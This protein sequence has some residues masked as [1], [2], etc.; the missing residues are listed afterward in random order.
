MNRLSSSFWGQHLD[1]AS[2]ATLLKQ[3]GTGRKW[4]N[5]VFSEGRPGQAVCASSEQTEI[6]TEEEY[7][8]RFQYIPFV[9][10]CLFW[11]CFSNRTFYLI[12]AYKL[13]K[14][15][16]C[17]HSDNCWCFEGER[18]QTWTIWRVNVEAL[19][20]CMCLLCGKTTYISSNGYPVISDEWR[21]MT[22][23][24]V[25]NAVFILGQTKWEKMATCLLDW[26]AV[27]VHVCLARCWGLF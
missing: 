6:Y 23:S 24:L 11:T 12:S 19:W 27:L 15:F 13:L 26:I 20:M 2:K 16:S 7:A 1:S 18:H 4:L 10:L 17:W 21:D 8:M 5:V 3:F 14:S 25:W 9:S 22:W